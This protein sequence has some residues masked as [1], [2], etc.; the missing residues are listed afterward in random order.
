MTGLRRRRWRVSTAP[1][2]TVLAIVACDIAPDPAEPL[3]GIALDVAFD[4]DTVIVLEES[5]ED[6]IA[7]PGIFQERANGGFLL[8]D[9]QLPKVR[10]YDEHG[11]LEAAFGRFG[12]GPFEFQGIDGLA[13]TGSG[14]VAVLDSRQTRLTWLTGE[15][16]ADTTVSLPGIPWRAKA[17]GDDLLLDM[18]LGGVS[19]GADDLSRFHRRPLM[20]HRLRENEVVWSSY[21]WPFLPAERPYWNSIAR[22]S[23]DVAGDSIYMA[24]SL[25][26]PV[27]ILHATGDSIGEFGVPPPT[28]EPVPVFESGAFGPGGYG[29]QIPELLGGRS[30]ISHI[31][32][33]GSYLAVVHGRFRSPRSGG[34]FGAYH[35]SLD[36]YDRDTGRKLYEGVPLPENSRVLGGGRH[37]YLLQD[38]R[39]P[40][41]RIVRLSLREESPG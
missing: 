24:F 4:T 27:A 32:V 11:R 23:F 1:F 25:R 41:W 31:A 2:V 9:G 38:T 39:F 18:R 5:P 22:F 40:P 35:A 19:G 8:S 15:L 20:L 29:T 33:V 30:T 6:S 28:F 21:T 34:A 14:R 12:V 17:I 26:Y 3:A 7:V 37:L 16:L 36:I 13:E 10:S